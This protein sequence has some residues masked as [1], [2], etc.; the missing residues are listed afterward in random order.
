MTLRKRLQRWMPTPESVRSNRSL[1]FLG[2]LL[3]RPWLWQLSRRRVAAGAAIGIFFGFVIPIAQILLAAGAAVLL[4]ANLP[5]AA[6]ATLITNP[7]TLAPLYVAAYY[8]GTAVLGEPANPQVV[9]SL[10]EGFDPG[11][12]LQRTSD[13]L[14]PWFTGLLV[15]AVGGA[16]LAWVVINAV[17][18]GAVRLRRRRAVR[19]GAAR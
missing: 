9:A 4:R 18:I 2:P 10:G 13:L 17:W 14:K 1:A 7:F 8:T 11:V 15:F 12:L 16:A 3:E 19:S 6:A 5:V